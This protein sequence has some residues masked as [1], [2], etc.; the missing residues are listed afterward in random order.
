M[1]LR[2][3]FGCPTHKMTDFQIK[4]QHSGRPPGGAAISATWIR[5]G[6]GALRIAGTTLPHAAFPVCC[7]DVPAWL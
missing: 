5:E 7:V 3:R 1:E 6:R 2:S 4:F